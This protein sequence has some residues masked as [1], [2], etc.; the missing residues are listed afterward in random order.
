MRKDMFDE[1]MQSVRE[2][3]EV[4]AG[5]MTPA[6]VTYV[7]D[8]IDDVPR[9]RA[10]FGLSQAK[11]AALIGISVATLQNWEQGRRVP[12]GPA[13]VLL[14]LAA[15]HPEALLAVSSQAAGRRVTVRERKA[16]A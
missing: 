2:M 10:S 14:R 11:F 9:L 12:D 1:L 4:E 16:R 6:R 8:L 3:K 5:R 7:E 13:K 15:T